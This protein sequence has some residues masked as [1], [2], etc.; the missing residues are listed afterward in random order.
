MSFDAF[1][2][3]NYLAVAVAAIAYF[4][5]GAIW[6]V[7]PVMGRTWQKA[8][9]IEMPEDGGGPNPVLFVGTYIAY[10]AAGLATAL[11]AVATQ[12]DSAAEGVVLGLVVGVG[13]AFTA[14]AV[15][16]L[17]DRKPQPMA[18]WLINGIFNVIG[19]VAV[20]VIIGAWR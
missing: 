3:V 19:L 20:G 18:W 10:A 8:G 2:D 13:Y 9:G 5:L 14:A 17:Y 15:T 1:S 4:V 7:P 6:Y 16:A 12:T 11:L